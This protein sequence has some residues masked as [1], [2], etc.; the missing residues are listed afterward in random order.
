MLFSRPW[1]SSGGTAWNSGIGGSGLACDSTMYDVSSDHSMLPSP[2]TSTCVKSSASL[3]T[4][5]S[6]SARSSSRSSAV[7][8]PKLERVSWRTMTST[9]SATSNPRSLYLPNSRFMSARLSLLSIIIR[10][11]SSLLLSAPSSSPGPLLLAAGPPEGRLR[12]A[13]AL[14]SELSA[15]GLASRKVGL[16]LTWVACSWVLP[17][18]SSRIRRRADGRATWRRGELALT[19]ELPST[20]TPLCCAVGADIAA[21]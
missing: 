14:A 15:S 11:L 12:A 4:N 18:W 1:S 17:F 20:S 10:P 21:R 13:A 5:A 7:P 16:K 2:L 8:A 3:A 9:N 6:R 19:L